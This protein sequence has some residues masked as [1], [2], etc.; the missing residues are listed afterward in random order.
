MR[1]PSLT[2]R[3]APAQ[4][5]LFAIPHIKINIEV[6]GHIQSFSMLTWSG[7]RLF[8]CQVMLNFGRVVT[9]SN[10]I[11]RDVSVGWVLVS[12]AIDQSLFAPQDRMAC[13]CSIGTFA[14]YSLAI[15]REISPGA[16]S[17]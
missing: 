17:P 8:W 3:S 7:K 15:L 14:R 1:S 2:R 6:K 9:I 10:W 16:I 11:R 5:S 13:E 4:L 12:V